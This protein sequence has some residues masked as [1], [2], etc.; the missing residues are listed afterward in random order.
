M[1]I[2]CIA[3]HRDPVI[4]S[5]WLKSR[6]GDVDLVLSA[7][8][9][10]LEYYGF[11][12]SSINKRLLFIFGNHNLSR[13]PM[14]R[15]HLRDPYS[16]DVSNTILQ[17]SFGSTYI[18][19]KVIREKDVI[20]AGLGGSKRYND[21]LNQFTEFGMFCMILRLMPK[22]LANKIFRGRYLDVLLTHAAPFGVGDGPDLCHQGF[23]I[24][25]WFLRVFKPKYHIHGH[26]HLYDMNAKRKNVYYSTE[27]INAYAHTIIEI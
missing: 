10:E 3:D 8:D 14:Y 26:I 21:S 7:G 24:F 17:P 6:Y 9:L 11:I 19:G 23:R 18:G 4:Y 5:S 25:L 15:K 22:L 27:V 20:F 16:R 13:L 2:L 12:V 1:K